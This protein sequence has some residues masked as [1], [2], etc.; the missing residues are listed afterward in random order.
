MRAGLI[1]VA[2]GLLGAAPA[3][4]ADPPGPLEKDAAAATSPAPTPADTST[5]VSGIV[6]E[7]RTKEA[8]QAFSDAV[9]KFV[10]AE[11][12][13]GRVHQLS[14]WTRP[15]CPQ[16]FGLRQ[17]Y[18]VYVAQRITKLAQK[19]GATSPGTCHGTNVLVIFTSQPDAL[20]ADVRDHHE[21]LLGPHYRDE[22]EKLAA[23]QPPM[24]SWFVTLTA[25][26]LNQTKNKDGAEV[27][28]FDSA[29]GEEQPECTRVHECTL[30][31]MKSMKSEFAFALVVV[32]ADRIVGKPIG[33]VAD[34]IA[35]TVLSKEAQRDGCGA[36]PT[37]MDLLDPAC[38]AA[39]SNKGL[40]A[41]DE[42]YLKALY[43]PHDTEILAYD[44]ARIER[45]VRAVGLSP[46]D[47]APEQVEPPPAPD[48]AT[49]A[50]SPTAAPP[51]QH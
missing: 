29:Y 12:Q 6:V 51:G 39:K 22:T 15:I 13:P 2:V 42:A 31:Y 47:E 14:R 10:H 8:L 7:G 41:Y 28:Q 34:E 18:D 17:D 44:R 27:R 50:Q 11:G 49:P 25:V 21:I 19:V 16:I 38:P 37:V 1:A 26:P 5:S 4:A 30:E 9:D 3:W 33:P 20:M 24:K 48:P 32:E 36:L 45:A 23:F 46:A 35:M 43:A 40:T